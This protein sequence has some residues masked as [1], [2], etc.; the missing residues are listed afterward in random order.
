MD[1]L[2]LYRE[3]CGAGH[4]WAEPWNALSN[5]VFLV[6]AVA[7]G[8]LAIRERALQIGTA[9]L[10]A[11]TGCIGLGS[12]AFH[13][14]P[15]PLTL[16]MDILPISLFQAVFLWL[17]GRA[18][19]GWSAG[20]TATLVV[21]VVGTAV[22]LIPVREPGNGS[23]FYGPPLVALAVLGGIFAFRGRRAGPLVL[24][25]TGLFFVAVVV[26][27]LDWQVPWP[28]GTHFGWH[29][30]NGGVLFLV[31]RAWILETGLGRIVPNEKARRPV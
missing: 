18:L 7:A 16:A 17:A 1:L 13:T 15:T 30:L 31:L 14:C 5:G 10:L 20:A 23:L 29:L 12:F 2:N 8:W 24:G 28:Q 4:F 9:V 25:A 3:R 22:A 19:L 21:G 27:T 6:V 26:R 11:L